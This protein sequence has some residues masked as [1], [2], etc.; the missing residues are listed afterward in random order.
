M[1]AASVC[2]IPSPHHPFI[3][4]LPLSFLSLP[5]SSFISFL[6]VIFLVIYLYLLPTCVLKQYTSSFLYFSQCL[7]LYLLFSSAWT[8]NHRLYMRSWIIRVSLCQCCGFVTFWYGSE[9]ADS[10]LSPVDSDPAPDP[11]FF[12]LDL[13]DFS[14]KK[15]RKEVKKTEGIEVCYYFCLMIEG[16]GS[17]HF[18]NGSGFGSG[19]RRPKTSVS[20]PQYFIYS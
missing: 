3:S 9:S 15:S 8:G 14:K 13:L 18:T 12:V 19:S 5:I 6:L 17:V 10:W 16:S 1:T 7:I 4:I 20:D 2:C 11:A